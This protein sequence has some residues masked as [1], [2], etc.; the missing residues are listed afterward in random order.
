V[1]GVSCDFVSPLQAV[2]QIVAAPGD[3]RAQLQEVCLTLTA[4]IAHYNWVGFYIADAVAREL[5]LGPYVGDPTD[6]L[7][8]GYGKGICGQAA[9]SNKTFLVQDVSKEDNYLACS[10]KVMA[11]IVVPVWY[12]SRFVG[13]LDIDSHRLAPFTTE[14]QFFC[15]GVARAVAGLV[16]ELAARGSAACGES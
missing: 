7:R 13:E 8:I 1:S 16:A 12:A 9:E 10:Q 3:A 14:D 6:H 2:K 11:E 5:W 4:R 15:E